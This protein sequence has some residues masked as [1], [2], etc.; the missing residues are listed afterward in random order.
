MAGAGS[1]FISSCKSEFSVTNPIR[2][3]L[4]PEYLASRMF[5]AVASGVP[6][7]SLLHASADGQHKLP[8]QK[9]DVKSSFELGSIV[10]RSKRTSFWRHPWLDFCPSLALQL[11]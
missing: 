3:V 5:M 1:V 8:L 7:W 9:G 11:D 6:R 10:W 4:S 2:G